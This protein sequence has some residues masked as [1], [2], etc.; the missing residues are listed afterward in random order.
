MPTQQPLDSVPVPI[1]IVI[2]ILLTLGCYEIGFRI[3]HRRHKA[4][5]APDDPATGVIVGAILGLMAFLLAVTMSM[6]GDRFDNRRSLVL[7]EANA[8]ST[9]YL[10]AGYLPQPAS[11]QLRQL[12]VEYVP[13][14][15]ATAPN[16]QANI[17]RSEELQRQM[18]GIAQDVARNNGSDVVA[19]FI[20]SLNETIDLHESRLAAGLYARVPPTIL[21]LLIGGAILSLGLVG[22]NAGLAG[23]RNPVIAVLLVVAIGAV[24]TLVVDLDRPADGF[25]QTNQQPL[26]D[27]QQ[28]IES[29]P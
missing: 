28:S 16:L 27:L 25:I 22:Y 18:W 7:A 19:L 24:I 15:I 26:I 2:F 6:A 8:I 5:D 10:R 14:R 12:L 21:W 3:G 23:R 9:T 13:L 29:F 1:F 20:E 17:V 4:G 11:D